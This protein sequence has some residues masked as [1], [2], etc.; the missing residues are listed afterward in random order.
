[1]KNSTE[2]HDRINRVINT[3][4]FEAT[5]HKHN[6]DLIDFQCDWH[7][8]SGGKFEKL[9]SAYQEAILAGE[10]ELQSVGETALA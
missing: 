2:L 3:T 1:M 10:A 9:P 8:V 4:A 6:L 7:Q 5:L